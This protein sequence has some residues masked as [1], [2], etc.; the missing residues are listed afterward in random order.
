MSRSVD[1]C[2][3]S[4]HRDETELREKIRKASEAFREK[5]QTDNCGEA[6]CGSTARARET[7]RREKSKETFREREVDYCKD[8]QKEC[9]EIR[10][11]L[12]RDAEEFRRGMPL[13]AKKK[14][15]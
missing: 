7:V 1:S 6:L 11:D 5:Y 13:R 15:M 14:R 4:L 3:N 8:V 9:R 2:H 12:H 10:A